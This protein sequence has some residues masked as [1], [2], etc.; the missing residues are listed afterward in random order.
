[1]AHSIATPP[2][3]IKRK[4]CKLLPQEVILDACRKAEYRWRERKFDPVVT[5]H[6]FILQVLHGNTAIG[7]LRHLVHHAVNAA[8]YCKARMRIP[9]AVYEALLDHAAH[10]ASRGC[11]PVF[12]AMRVFLVDAASS[13]TPDTPAIR[14]LFQQP[15]N[16]KPGCGLPMAKVLALFDAASG[17]ILRPLI[18][19]LF[20]HEA[21]SVWRLHPLLRA[22]DLIVGDRA[23]CSYAHLAMLHARDVFGLFRVQQRQQVDFRRGRRHGGKGK[24]KSRFIRKLGPCDQLVEWVKPKQKPKWMSRKQFAALPKGLVVRELR[25]HLQARGQRTRVVTVVTTLTDPALYS[26]EKIAEL[27]G[28]RWQVETHFAQLKTGMKMARLKCKSPEGVKKEL[29]TCFIAYNLTRAIMREAAERQGVLPGR[30]SFI[31]ALRWLADARKGDE[32]IVLLV[33]PVRP[34]RHEPRVKKYLKYRYRPMTRPRHILKKR[35]YLYADK[36]K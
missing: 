25:Y 4:F 35:P 10:L 27:Y 16:I 5:V 2:L 3:Q 14:K 12:A 34:D 9:L 22:G 33:I 6:L 7:H 11:E 30:I 8:A 31:D 15:K 17:A 36:A 18:C 23:F 19:S 24:P 29:L 13:L 26:A 1:M 20:V 28:L 32:L 21:S